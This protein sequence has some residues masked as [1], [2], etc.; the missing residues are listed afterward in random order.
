MDFSSA[1]FSLNG[2]PPALLPDILHLPG[3]VVR[4]SCCVTVEELATG[5]YTGPYKTPEVS[6][7]QTFDWDSSSLSFVVRDKTTEELNNRKIPR[8]KKVREWLKSQLESSLHPTIAVADLAPYYKDKLVDY[9]FKL[10]ALYYSSDYLT[11]SDIP[12]K[13][14][15]KYKTKSEAETAYDAVFELEEDVLKMQYETLGFCSVDPELQPF[16]KVKSGWVA[17]SSYSS[18]K[19]EL[20]H[21]GHSLIAF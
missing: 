10:H 20:D 21:Y 1:K 5:G 18:S 14:D 15:C 7:T 11:Y 2:A 12:Q 17:A 19:F 4:Q 3:R 16:F 13:P 8:D 6:E 9:Y